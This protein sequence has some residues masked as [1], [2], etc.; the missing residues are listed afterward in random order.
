[1]PQSV[2]H[3]V[4]F[5]KTKLVDVDFEAFSA[6]PHSLMPKASPPR[7][8]INVVCTADCLTR[9]AQRHTSQMLP[10]RAIAIAIVADIL[11]RLLLF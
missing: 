5:Q 9:D 6:Q 4:Q 2:L 10:L 3:Q 7:N 11:P 1:M 8:E